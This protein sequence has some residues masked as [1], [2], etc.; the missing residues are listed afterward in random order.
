MKVL[1]GN[2]NGKVSHV[3]SGFQWLLDHHREYNIRVV[4]ISVGATTDRKT[5]EHSPLY[6]MVGKLWDAGMVVI[7]AAG[8]EGPRKGSITSPGIHPKIITVGCS[9]DL[10][11]YHSGRG[12]VPKSC[13]VKP[14]VLAPGANVV[15]CSNKLG[16]T[17][18]SGTS[19]ATP[20]VTGAMALLCE[21]CPTLTNGQMKLCLKNSSKDLHLPKSQQGWGLLQIERLIKEGAFLFDK[22]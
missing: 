5:N 1:D 6:K 12:P 4:N 10:R 18:K 21:A 8:N 22:G 3:L 17:I 19:M 7:A 15:S 9:D 11:N 20:R 13:V 16:Y 14:E 2:G